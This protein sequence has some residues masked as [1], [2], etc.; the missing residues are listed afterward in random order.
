MLPV[1]WSKKSSLSG[2]LAVDQVEVS[3]TLQA[4]GDLAAFRRQK[5][6]EQCQQVV[7]GIT[8]SCGKTTVKEMVFSIL[9]RMWP[10]GAEYPAD[11]VLKTTG[12]FN[13]LIGLP[14]SLLPL[15][16]SHRAAV[17]EMG[18]NRPGELSRLGTIADPDVSCITNI[19][20][21]HL[22]G[23][24]SIEGVAKAKEELFGATRESGVLVVNLDDVRIRKLSSKYNNRQ[25][26][27]AVQR[28]AN[29]PDA[30]ENLRGCPISGRRIST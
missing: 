18:M 23:L 16:V 19:H 22:E 10:A 5:L 24:Q 11:C 12:N 27:F 28:E 3:D 30:V 6:A 26:T 29:V 21:A 17:L 2:E 25:I 13:N 4:L 7:I 8:G 14:L 15:D 9:A 20:G 1:W